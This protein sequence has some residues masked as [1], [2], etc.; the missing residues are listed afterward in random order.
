[1]TDPD[2]DR[3]CGLCGLNLAA[4]HYPLCEECLERHG[5]L[6]PLGFDDEGE[7]L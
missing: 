7:P 2:R 5:P 6:E 1:M 4:E 3:L